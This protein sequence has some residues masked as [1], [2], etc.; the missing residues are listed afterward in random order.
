[1]GNVGGGGIWVNREEEGGKKEE[2]GY[3]RVWLA[4]G[5]PNAV[6]G[7]HGL[8]ASL[9]HVVYSQ[10]GPRAHQRG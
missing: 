10:G 7:E 3:T 5:K 9:A 1:M 6:G 4:Q 2:M 8:Q